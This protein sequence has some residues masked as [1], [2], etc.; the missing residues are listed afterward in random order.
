MGR[1][2]TRPQTARETRALPKL[3]RERQRSG[4]I[5]IRGTW[6]EVAFLEEFTEVV[7]GGKDEG[8]SEPGGYE[9]ELHMAQTFSFCLG[10]ASDWAHDGCARST[11]VK[12]NPSL[13]GGLFTHGPEA[14]QADM[15]IEAGDGNGGKLTVWR[16]G[17]GLL[18]SKRDADSAKESNGTFLRALNWWNIIDCPCRADTFRALDKLEPF[19]FV[20]LRNTW[21][22]VLFEITSVCT[23]VLWQD[24]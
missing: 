3:A 10:M 13:D 8:A 16:Y 7:F 18:R 11:G 19:A 15:E 1:F 5:R 24:S 20:L 6:L 21:P 9:F 17:L 22:N 2:A 14:S 23:L 12:G 4:K